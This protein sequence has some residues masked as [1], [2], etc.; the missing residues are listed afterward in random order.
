MG[1]NLIYRWR[2]GQQPKG[3]LGQKNSFAAIDQHALLQHIQELEME[4]DICSC[5]RASASGPKKR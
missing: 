3:K 5:R 2:S 1:E 4:R